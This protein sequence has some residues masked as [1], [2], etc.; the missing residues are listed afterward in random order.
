MLFAVGPMHYPRALDPESAAAVQF[1]RL[2][3]ASGADVGA[4]VVPDDMRCR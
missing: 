3:T 4:V 2:A 1:I